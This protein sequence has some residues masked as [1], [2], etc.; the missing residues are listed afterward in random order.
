MIELRKLAGAQILVSALL[1]V[2]LPAFANQ[3]SSSHG[4]DEESLKTGGI[5]YKQAF[6]SGDID[7]LLSFWDESAV[8]ADQFGNIY[9][10]KNEIKEQIQSFFDK[11][12]P[13][14]LEINVETITFPTDNVAIETGVTRLSNS[15]A[16]SAAAHYVATHVKR[17][18]KWLMESVNETPYKAANNG[19][20]L[21]PLS[22]LIGSWKA[23]HPNGTNLEI[24]LTWANKNVIKRESQI[25]T[26]DGGKISQT[27]YIF[28]NPEGECISSWQFDANG[29]TSH[30]WWEKSGD[31]WV[32]HASS[33]Q[34][35]GSQ[36]R[37]DYFLQQAGNDS[38]NWQSKNRNLAG[39]T[40]PD[41]DVVKVSRVKG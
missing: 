18:G 41:T 39:E 12:G 16:P 40:L 30:S 31:S 1:A 9:R 35:D 33:L 6:A 26:K 38:F 3:T 37:A 7:K 34:A 24:S 2:S 15:T 21:K 29:G 19:D 5:Q 22:W 8:Y 11:Y 14:P 13:Q 17:D 36:S 4:A 25:V 32:V 28:W 20:Y 27:E 10:N 23:A